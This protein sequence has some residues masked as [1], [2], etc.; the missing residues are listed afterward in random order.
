[1]TDQPEFHICQCEILN[2]PVALMVG[3][4]HVVC[5]T[6]FQLEDVCCSLFPLEAWSLLVYIVLLYLK[7]YAIISEST[8]DTC[9]HL[10][11]EEGEV[12]ENHRVV[13]VLER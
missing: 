10:G 5:S 8:Q 13:S 9:G 12:L 1:M 4:D 7:Y 11:R 2:P 6:C 3:Y